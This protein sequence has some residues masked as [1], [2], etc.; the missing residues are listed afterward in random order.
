MLLAQYENTK[1]QN[2][3]QDVPKQHVL[4]SPSQ[5]QRDVRQVTSP[6]RSALLSADMALQDVERKSQEPRLDCL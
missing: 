1:T 6:E 4:S 5:A 3:T 2:G